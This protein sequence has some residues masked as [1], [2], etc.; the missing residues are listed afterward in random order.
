MS[1]PLDFDRC[2]H[3][4]IHVHRDRGFLGDSD[5]KFKR[6]RNLDRFLGRAQLANTA[7][8][9]STTPLNDRAEESDGRSEPSRG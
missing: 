9:D 2:R 3:R 7:K 1:W 4:T 5:G 6:R 8:T